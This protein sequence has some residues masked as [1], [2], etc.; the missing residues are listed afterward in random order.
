MPCFLLSLHKS[1]MRG[2][3]HLSRDVSQERKL[4][5]ANHSVIFLMH[6]KNKKT[7]PQLSISVSTEKYKGGEGPT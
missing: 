2:L 7:E 3:L 4:M 1:K 6:K 5:S